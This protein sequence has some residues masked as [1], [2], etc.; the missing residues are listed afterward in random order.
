M[1]HSKKKVWNELWINKQWLCM[2]LVNI[3]SK[4]QYD[5]MMIDQQN[6]NNACGMCGCVLKR[7]RTSI[8]E[9]WVM[10]VFGQTLLQ[11]AGSGSEVPAIRLTIS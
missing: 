7:A 1:V 11:A 9:F 5:N 8:P 4:I 3:S 2:F 6:S 10:R